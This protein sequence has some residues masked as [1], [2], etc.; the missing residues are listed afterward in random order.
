MNW[1]AIALIIS[2]A[3]VLAVMAWDY[4]KPKSDKGG[5]AHG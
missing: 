4:R 3:S 1:I 2:G 5:D